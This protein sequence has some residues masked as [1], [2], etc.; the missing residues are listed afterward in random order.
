MLMLD[1]TRLLPKLLVGSCPQV[2]EDI[3]RLKRD[4]AVTAVLNLQ[5]DDD[6]AYWGIAWEQLEEYYRVQGIEVRRVPIRDFDAEDLRRRLPA[7]AHAVRELLEQGHT[8]LVHCSAG[9]NRSPST[10]IAYLH[11]YQAMDLVAAAEAVT[12]QRYCEPDV[13][14]IRLAGLDRGQGPCG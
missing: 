11:W 10:V 13:G 6:F 7:A 5:T 9:V 3:D 8:L 4:Y 14:T 2:F 1:V 12:S